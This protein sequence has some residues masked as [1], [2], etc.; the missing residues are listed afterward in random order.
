LSVI[1]IAETRDRAVGNN[2]HFVQWTPM[3]NGDSGA[4][5]GMTGFA[6]RSAQI[7]GTFGTGGTV[8][9][10][11]S[12]DGT[13]YATLNDPR[14]SSSSVRG[15]PPA[16]APRASQ[17]RCWRGGPPDE[18]Q[19]GKFNQRRTQ[20]ATFL[21][22]TKHK[23][24]YGEYPEVSTEAWP[25]QHLI[26]RPRDDLGHSIVEFARLHRRHPN[27]PASPWSDRHGKIYLSP[28]LDEPEPE[29]DAVPRYRL[30]EF[31]ALGACVYAK[32]A[33]V[34][35]LG[36]PAR[37]SL[38]EPVNESAERVMGYMARCAGRPLPGTM[39][40]SG[41]VLNLPSPG[42]DDVPQNYTHRASGPFG[43]AA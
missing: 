12:N 18:R 19:A 28:D 10:E 15:Y 14:S 23:T 11:G 32:G 16:T 35:F 37:P 31:G 24:P 29:F 34:N 33:E 5:F 3:L 40:H 20:V 25:E 26:A 21:D 42:R 43:D 6:D 38:L 8:L 39:P 30:K 4:P 7:V 13:N 22:R 2:V 41:G 27:F 36:W 17:S 9:I 1:A